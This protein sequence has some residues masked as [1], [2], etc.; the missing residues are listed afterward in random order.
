MDWRTLAACRDE[1]PELFFPVGTGEASRADV[2]AAKAVCRGCPV[3]SPCLAWA[4]ASGQDAGVWGGTSEGER[5]ALR[6]AVRV[7][8][9]RPG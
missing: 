8:A 6:R 9:R 5:R 2:A 7:R 4:L 3:V 1:D